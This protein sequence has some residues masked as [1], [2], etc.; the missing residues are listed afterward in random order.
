M[1]LLASLFESI[2]IPSSWR[3]PLTLLA[4]MIALA[5]L[6]FIG[7]VFAKE[8]SDRGHH[9]LM[10]GGLASFS[11]LFIVYARILQTAELSIVT[12]GWV[13]FLQVG[14]IAMDRLYYGVTLP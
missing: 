4:A 8:W 14:I 13:V 11:L 9:L 10:I 12:L 5:V 3:F 6:D 7:A 2:S 1:N